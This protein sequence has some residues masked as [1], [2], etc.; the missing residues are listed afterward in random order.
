MHTLAIDHLEPVLMT[1]WAVFMDTEIPLGTE[2]LFRTF[3]YLIG[4][5]EA[6]DNFLSARASRF[7]PQHTLAVI[8][9]SLC[10]TAWRDLGGTAVLGWH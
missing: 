4:D 10:R 3:G 5:T 7:L 8:Q 9:N 6:V 1:C 2:S